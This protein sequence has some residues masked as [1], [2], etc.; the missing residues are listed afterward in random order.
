MTDNIVTSYFQI[1]KKLSLKQARW[2]DF[3]AKFDYQLE[4]KPRK[5]NVV[6]NALGR[7]SELAML[8]AGIAQSNFL[9]WIKEGMQ[10]DV[11]ASNLIRSASEE[12]AQKILDNRWSLIYGW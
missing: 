5:A 8:T 12:K 4:Y 11:L 1:Q 6:T 7:K 9:D 10:R 3:L 2:Q